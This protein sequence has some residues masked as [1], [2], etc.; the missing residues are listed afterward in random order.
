MNRI[1]VFLLV[2]LVVGLAG[3][4]LFRSSQD[5]QTV[6]PLSD[7]TG[8]SPTRVTRNNCLD[9]ECLKTGVDYPV[10]ELP[11]KVQDS[12]HQALMDEYKAYAT[13]KTVLDTY[14][15][16]RPF[17][18]IARAEQKHIAAL[19][20]LYE[21]YGIE[22]PEN[23]LLETI[24]APRSIHEA[25]SVGVQSEINNVKLYK[26]SLLPNVTDYEDITIVFTNLM[27][28]SEQKHLPAFQ[29]CD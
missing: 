7:N 21:K 1:M 26:E 11:A 6:A 19:Q 18:M 20:G 28:A 14:G 2:T 8:T 13:Y 12:L 27:N 24:P 15:N 23:N 4:Y 22:I 9:D 3:G 25:C 17:I 10:T 29:Q 5:F 16:V